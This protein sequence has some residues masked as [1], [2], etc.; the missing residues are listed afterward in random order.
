MRLTVG[1]YEEN[2]ELPDGEGR[3]WPSTGYDRTPAHLDHN[4]KLV[5]NPS[6]SQNGK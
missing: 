3:K 5:E 1:T 4:Q 6:Q 2:N